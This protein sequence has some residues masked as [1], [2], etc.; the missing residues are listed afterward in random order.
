MELEVQTFC[1]YYPAYKR[2][3]D[4]WDS[5][6]FCQAV[7]SGTVDG[8]F[9]LPLQSGRV[10]V[11]GDDGRSYSFARTVFGNNIKTAVGG[12][13]IANYIYVPAPSKDSFD[14]DDFRSY[15]MLKEAL[16]PSEVSNIRPALRFKK[17][18]EQA[19]QG[20]PRG[21][22]AILPFLATTED[23]ADQNIVLVDDIVTSG[24]TLLACKDVIE[25][26]GGKVVFAVA[27][28]RTDPNDREPFS[29]KA[30]RFQGFEYLDLG[31]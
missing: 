4:G 16:G 17:K 15:R 30:I 13:G 5:T 21:Y 23:L 10:K 24:G 3:G 28:G 25:K 20:G 6:K 22:N 14:I 26:A 31:F 19:S 8:H 7:K 1:V 9:H 11:G 29:K 27:A 18:V 2:H 12:A